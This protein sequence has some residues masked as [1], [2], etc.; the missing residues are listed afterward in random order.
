MLGLA[1]A[2]SIREQFVFSLAE[3]KQSFQ[4]EEDEDANGN[5]KPQK[6]KIPDEPLFFVD[7]LF[8]TLKLSQYAAER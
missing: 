3:N 2:V 8:G 6:K 1:T 7:G 5:N 4:A